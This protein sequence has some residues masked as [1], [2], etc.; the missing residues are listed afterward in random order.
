M[1]DETAVQPDLSLDELQF[2]MTLWETRSLTSAAS[3]HR[4]SMGSAS[5]R[6]AH[7]RTVFSDELFVRSGLVMLPTGRMRALYP[8]VEAVLR[9]S[10]S[11]FSQE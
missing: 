7:L 8:R 11:L 9:S 6:L 3:R 1:T 4:M 5:R 2:L 10:Q